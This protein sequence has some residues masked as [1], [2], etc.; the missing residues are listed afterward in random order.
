MLSGH[1]D[2]DADYIVSGIREGFR[3]G[4]SQGAKTTKPLSSARKNMQ[5]AQENP[6]VVEEYLEEELARGVLLGPFQW[7]EV[8]GVHLNR[9][10]VIPKSSQPG[11]W[12]PIV[13]LS[14]PEEKSVNDGINPSHCS[15]QY[16]RVD[17]VV[18]QLLRLGPG[19][20]MAKLDVKS[21]YRIVPV[22]P[23]D[24]LSDT[25]MR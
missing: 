17:D 24:R 18:K 22:H 16:V 11:K 14:R 15:L 23:E 3:V 5:S 6:H 19:A 12:R 9:F 10:G 4:Y 21:A 13:D 7:E 20:L 8:A 25:M 1:P 2:R